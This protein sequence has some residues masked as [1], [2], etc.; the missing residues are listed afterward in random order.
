M[1]ELFHKHGV[2]KMRYRRLYCYKTDGTVAKSGTKTPKQILYGYH[3][4]ICGFEPAPVAMSDMRRD[5]GVT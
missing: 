2:K 4:S 1:P 5:L 3:C